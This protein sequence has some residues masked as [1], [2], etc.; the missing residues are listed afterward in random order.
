MLQASFPDGQIQVL[1][2]DGEHFEVTIVS[3][4]FEGKQLVQQHQL[5]YKAVQSAIQTEAIHA[6]SLKTYTPEAWARQAS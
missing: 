2:P 4:Q 5:V 3:A 1:S 6:L